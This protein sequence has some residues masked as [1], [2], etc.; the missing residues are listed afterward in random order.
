MTTLAKALTIS[1][2]WMK[3]KYDLPNGW[4]CVSCGEEYLQDTEGKQVADYT[5]VS[6]VRSWPRDAR[7]GNRKV[8]QL[9]IRSQDL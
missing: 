5:Q 6:V 7:A 2:R 1:Q 8:H 3:M 9:A 4:T